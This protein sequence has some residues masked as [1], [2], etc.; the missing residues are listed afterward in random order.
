MFNT[1]S[2][3]RQDGDQ[4]R[5]SNSSSSN[6]LVSAQ[7]TQI[8][9]DN[10]HRDHELGDLKSHRPHQHDPLPPSVDYSQVTPSARYQFR[11]LARRALS[12]HRRQRF[13]SVCCL[14]VWPVLLVVICFIITLIGGDDSTL[15]FYGTVA[16]CVNEA[17]PNTSLGFR[18]DRV[19][20][21][22]N[23]NSELNVAWYR[24][25]FTSG[26]DRSSDPLPC[27]RWFGES[28]PI[29]V[30]YENTTATDA[31]EPSA[32]YTPPPPGGWFK[33][34]EIQKTWNQENGEFRFTPAMWKLGAINQTIFYMAS[35]SQ[36]AQ[37]LG[38]VSNVTH[39]FLSESWPPTNASIVY[40][41]TAPGVKPGT[42]LLGAIP[43]RYANSDM[44]LRVT[45]PNGTNEYKDTVAY[46]AQTFSQKPDQD[47]LDQSIISLVK[48]LAASYSYRKVKNMP[49][50]AVMFDVLDPATSSIKMTMQFGQPSAGEYS[51]V[52]E[53]TPSGLRQIIT[54]AQMSGAMV[55][56][57]YA[58]KYLISQGLR[59]LP[60]KWDPK[61][62]K[63]R[64]LN[65]ISLYLFPFGLSF[66]LPTFVSIL[67]Q[68][69]EHRHRMMMAMNGLKP[70]PY[71]LAHYVEFMTMQMILSLFF[72]LAC[73]AIS[74]QL[75]L[76]T[77][78]LIIIVL[79]LVWAHAQTTLAFLLAACFSKTRRATLF[80]YFFVAISCIMAGVAGQIFKDGVPVAWA[81]HPSF[82]FFHIL[83]SGVLHAG[84][85]NGLYPLI[86]ADFAA[87]TFLFKCLMLLV[88]ESVIFVL[89]TFYIDAV[90]PSE[91]GVQKSWH[92]PI[93]SLFQ[94]KPMAGACDPESR[95]ASHQHSA[96]DSHDNNVLE[97][98][99][100]DVYAERDRVRTQYNPQQT[101]LII[102]NLFHRY[103]G[104]I[105]PALKGM[106]FGVENNTV[107]GLLGPNGA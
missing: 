85:V 19:P 94:K 96:L 100:A 1:Q 36:V 43:V 38:T 95:L 82:S 4:M 76:R 49:F 53:V 73:A 60:Y 107:L 40:N 66:L 41:S 22:S 97:G 68:E 91:Y 65:E 79:L 90:A 103:P 21:P 77:N 32:Y 23:G 7:H 89:L 14:V 64:T 71:Y 99:D 39:S 15:F 78:P 63:G 47:S 3:H 44:S 75:V 98:G 17:D 83:S 12:Y 59:A 54:M 58:G 74:S 92:F 57:K 6:A 8:P 18:M 16:F 26:A 50:G 25:S 69:K 31:A 104:K 27:V 93:T 80:V 56:T 87:G 20:Y 9:M 62:L 13:T 52:D 29:K 67:V 55:K 30:P 88:G 84:R 33:S 81:I 70:I 10:L 35:N 48:D 72:C 28:Y 42:G 101:P 102:D 86:W 11:A 105:E 106:S 45:L 34:R 24:P 51:Y 37:Q 61:I 5:L 2:N 46:E